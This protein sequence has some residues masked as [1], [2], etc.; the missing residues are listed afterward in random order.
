MLEKRE[1][2]MITPFKYVKSGETGAWLNAQVLD[3][4]VM[5]TK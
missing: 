3:C 2:Y 5:N 4:G 1:I